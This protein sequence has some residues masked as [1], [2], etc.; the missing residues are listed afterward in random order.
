MTGLFLL[1]TSAIMQAVRNP[2]GLVARRI[3]RHSAT[4]VTSVIVESEIRAHLEVSGRPVDAM[5]LLVAAHARSL[6]ATSI[7]ANVAHFERVPGLKWADW[8]GP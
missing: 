6:A 3:D 2:T 1:D 5:D 4:V 7:T 8:E